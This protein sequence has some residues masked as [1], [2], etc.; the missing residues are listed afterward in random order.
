MEVKV[1]TE[2]AAGGE[3]P[4]GFIL[5]GR[6]IKIEEIM[7]RWYSSRGNYYRVLGADGNFYILRG[8]AEGEMWELVS[9]THKDSRGTEPEFEGSK[10]LQ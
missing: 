6:F 5:G 9:F 1:E 3:K 2:I 4:A 8:P 10:E 7:D